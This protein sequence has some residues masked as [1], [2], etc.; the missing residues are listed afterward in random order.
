MGQNV[1][2]MGAMTRASCLKQTGRQPSKRRW[3]GSAYQVLHLG[4][5]GAWLWEEVLENLQGLR[6]VVAREAA[7]D[8]IVPS[9]AVCEIPG[10]HLSVFRGLRTEVFGCSRFWRVA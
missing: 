4:R 7:V 8:N 5:A 3:P 9:K 1:N 6:G 10:Q 2:V